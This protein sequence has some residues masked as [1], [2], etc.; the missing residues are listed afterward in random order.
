MESVYWLVLLAVLLIVEICT[1]GLTTI[2][3]AG[4]A[5]MAAIASLLGF[6]PVIQFVVFL[7][8]SIVLLIFTRPLALH[9][10]NDHRSK[11][12]YE[13][14]IGKMIKITERVDN[15]NQTGTASVNGQ[16]WTVRSEIDSV[17]L[18]SGDKAKIVNIS[19][20]KL[21]VRAYGEEEL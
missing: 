15:F 5:L 20:V 16:E 1:L 19:G 18:N 4:G 13:G 3:F 6:G 8:V 2:W 17:I 7:A 11:T 14:L 9:Y 10:I 12:N 21:I